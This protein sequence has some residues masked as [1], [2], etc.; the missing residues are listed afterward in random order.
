MLSFLYAFLMEDEPKL[1]EVLEAVKDGFGLM[2]EKFEKIDGR[3]DAVDT[4]FDRLERRMDRQEGKI[5]IL[6]NV[7]Q[8]KRIITEDDKKNIHA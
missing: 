4:R 3:F 7:L 1:S 6:V 2:D 5:T 8:E